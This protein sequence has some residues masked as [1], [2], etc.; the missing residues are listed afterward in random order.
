MTAQTIIRDIRKQGISV[1][2]VGS[3][4]RLHGPTDVLNHDIK[5]LVRKH[6][7]EIVSYLVKPVEVQRMIVCLNGKPCDF[8]S[9][10]N[11][12]QIC[13]KNE[14]PIF[15]MNACPAGKWEKLKWNS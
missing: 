5:N 7:K 15:D 10:K 4:I 2:L 8:I 12:R 3:K 9:L 6:K 11:D 14:Q 13:K 1:R